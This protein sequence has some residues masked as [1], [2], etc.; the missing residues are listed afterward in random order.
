MGYQIVDKT[1][2]FFMETT[3]IMLKNLKNN[4]ISIDE[5][6]RIFEKE[7]V[8]LKDYFDK[9]EKQNDK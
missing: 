8:K 7:L 5:A 6:I 3:I 9:I 2:V 1:P 4:N